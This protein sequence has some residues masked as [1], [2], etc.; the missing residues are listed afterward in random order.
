MKKLFPYLDLALFAYAGSLAIVMSFTSPF[1]NWDILGYIGATLALTDHATTNIHRLTFQ[2]I[3]SYF[4]PEVFFASVNAPFRI[5]LLTDPQAFA[6]QLPFYQIRLGYTSLVHILSLTGISIIAA[7]HIISALSV[8]VALVLLFGMSRTFLAPKLRIAIPLAALAFGF[9]NIA[10]T[11]TPDGLALLA[12]IG[13]SFLYLKNEASVLVRLL[14]MLGFIRTD[15]S[16]FSLIMLTALLTQNAASKRAIAASVAATLVVCFGLERAFGHPGWAT[17]LYV[18]L[19]QPLPYPLSQPPTV[20]PELYANTLLQGLRTLAH[21][22]SFLIYATLSLSCTLLLRKVS[23]GSTVPSSP[24]SQLEVICASYIALH[25]VALPVAWDR[26][27]AAPYLMGVFALLTM[28]TERNKALT[29]RANTE[30]R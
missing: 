11:S 3:Q 24:A 1:L 27:F 13:S 12:I 9:T 20:T 30:Q 10:R 25:F 28:L 2:T 15:L 22:G 16:L 29:Q 21:E 14:P 26:F 18:T 6:Q 4:P 19:V 7:T 5:A 8:A 17:I 23:K